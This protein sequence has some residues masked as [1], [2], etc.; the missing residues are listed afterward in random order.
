MSMLG[1]LILDMRTSDRTWETLEDYS[2]CGSE[3][4]AHGELHSEPC[5]G[6][7]SLNMT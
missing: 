2:T 1:N 7:G 4:F 6:L 3:D 5:P